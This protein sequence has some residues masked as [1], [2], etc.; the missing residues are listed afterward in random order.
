MCP[1]GCGEK[2]H[3][4]RRHSDELV[5]GPRRKV[6]PSA[7]PSSQLLLSSWQ[8]RRVDPEHAG[9]ECGVVQEETEGVAPSTTLSRH[10]QSSCTSR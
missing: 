5:E 1:C 8:V 4:A 6:P 10:A 9:V 7:A 3:V 2:I